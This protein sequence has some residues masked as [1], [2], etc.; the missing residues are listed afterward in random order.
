MSQHNERDDH[1]VH[2]VNALAVFAWLV[3]LTGAEIGVV[4]MHLSKGLL[5]TALI[6]SALV[7][8]LLVAIY[9]MHLKFEGKLIWGLII[10]SLILGTVFL[11]GLFPDIVCSTLS[12]FK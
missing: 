9:F 2:K 12:V 3:V 7:K 5:V 6:G 8:A 1:K 11:L 10:G 4:F